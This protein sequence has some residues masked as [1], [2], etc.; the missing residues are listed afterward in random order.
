MASPLQAQKSQGSNRDA[1]P[2]VKWPPIR[3]IEAK[4]S[5]QM[6][7]GSWQS[8]LANRGLA[9]SIGLPQISTRTL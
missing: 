7:G 8:A 4:D 6:T 9:L 5:T 3:G 1:S 2:C